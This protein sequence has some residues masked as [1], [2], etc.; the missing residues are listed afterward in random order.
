MKRAKIYLIFI[1][2]T[3]LLS[4]CQQKAQDPYVRLVHDEAGQRVDVFVDDQYFTSYLYTDTIPNLKKTILYPVRTMQG[5]NLTRGFPLDAI[6]GERVDHPHHIGHW[7]NYGDVNGLDFWNNS[8]AIPA[9]RVDQMGVIRHREITKS[10]E[11]QGSATL[12]VI[13]D[14][15]K[16]DGTVVIEENTQFIFRA[17][18]DMRVIDRVTTLTALEDTVI[19]K[20]NKEG[21][22]AIRVTRALE[23]PAQKAIILSDAHGNATEVPVLDNEGITGKYVSSRGIQGMEVWGK[24]AEWVALT[25]TVKG[26]K[27]ILAI[28]DHPHNVG[29]PTYWHARGYGL[30]AANPLG[31]KIFS[32]GKEELNFTLQPSESVTFKYRILILSGEMDMMKMKKQYEQFIAQ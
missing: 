6:P 32:E 9:E 26:E 28:L 22:I 8:A 4:S 15:L 12:G 23:H 1:L 18:A 24:R 20:D 16:S 13:A 2:F 7:L 25:G 11:G 10:Q 14:W 30:F 27:I 17:T 19:F 31:Q 5:N 21:M 29:Y 3:L